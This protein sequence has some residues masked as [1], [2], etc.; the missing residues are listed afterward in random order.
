[1]VSK[2]KRWSLIFSLL[3]LIVA[4]TVRVFCES[5]NILEIDFCWLIDASFV[6]FKRGFPEYYYLVSILV[7]GGKGGATF[8]FL[9]V[10]FI[11]SSLNV[12]RA[13][14]L[15]AFVSVILTLIFA[16][17]GLRQVGYRPGQFGYNRF[18]EPVDSLYLLQGLIVDTSGVLKIDASAANKTGQLSH[19]ELMSASVYQTY[20]RELIQVQK[21]HRKIL[22]EWRDQR[23]KVVEYLAKPINS[24]GFY[25]I[26]FDSAEVDTRKVLLLG[27]SFTWG[28]VTEHKLGSFANLL[29]KEGYTIYNTGISGVGVPQYNAVLKTYYPT[30]KPDVVVLNFFMGNDVAYFER[31][32]LP[33]VPV[34]FNTNAGNIMSMQ[35]GVQFVNEQEAYTTLMSNLKIQELSVINRF[36]AKTVITTYLWEFLSN[37]GIVYRE[38][39]IGKKYPEESLTND[40]LQP[41]VEYCDSVSVPLIVSVIPELSNGTL[42]GVN[43]EKGLFLNAEFIEPTTL[44]PEMYDRENGHFNDQGHKVYSEYLIPLIDSCLQQNNG[45]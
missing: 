37:Y 24:E 18:V 10:Y 4:V 34:Y 6:E 32:M 3:S 17:I 13:N 19:E 38:F 30:L 33:G 31:E 28:H 15:L 44:T 14:L 21:D 43:S 36:F 20:N 26:S 12:P 29:L 41:I 42:K 25:S 40:L 16:E 27:D 39:F 8:L 35:N 2:I 11:L 1:M 23:P 9:L 22:E 5:I 7:L 45:K